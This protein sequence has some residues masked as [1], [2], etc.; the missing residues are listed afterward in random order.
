MSVSKH[1]KVEV[2]GQEWVNGEFTEVSFTDGPGGV[3]I[4]AKTGR[5]GGSANSSGGSLIDL[6]TSASRAR[7]QAVVEEKQSSA[8][9]ATHTADVV[10]AEPVEIIHP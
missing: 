6:L 3:R 1:L 2:N 10:E 5:S 4:E 8:D 7:T 9:T